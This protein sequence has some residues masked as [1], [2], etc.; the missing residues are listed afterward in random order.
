MNAG[1]RL[2]EAAGKPEPWQ[3]APKKFWQKP[4]VPL[5]LAGVSLVLLAAVA[6]LWSNGTT[7][8]ARITK[9]EKHVAEQPLDP[10]TTTRTVRV[11]PNFKG[12]S[13]SPAVVIGGGDAQLADLKLDL[14]RSAYRA[15]RI[16]IDRIDQGASRFCKTSGRIPTGTCGLR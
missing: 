1:L 16:T 12:S 14:S 10:A 3:E 6:V 15:F 8:D 5:A 11:L 13:N 7:K 4:Q 9:L 2:L